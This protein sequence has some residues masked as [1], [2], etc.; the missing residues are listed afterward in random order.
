MPDAMTSHWLTQLSNGDMMNPET[1]EVFRGRSQDGTFVYVHHRPKLK[2]WFMVFQDAFTE[3]AKDRELWGQPTAVLHFLMGK[4]DFENHI[5]VQQVEIASALNL[6]KTRVSEAM[7]KLVDKGVI[8]KGPKIGRTASYKLNINYGWK[9]KVVNFKKEQGKRAFE[10][11]NGGM[12]S[13]EP[14]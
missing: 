7:K 1:G 11:I 10:V 2:G 9:G 13:Q 3:L 12:E 5:L 6:P 4:L 8:L 14:I